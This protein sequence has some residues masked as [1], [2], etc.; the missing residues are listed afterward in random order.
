[1][2]GA[3]PLDRG[4]WTVLGFTLAYLAGFTL[5]FLAAG[6]H[7]FLWYIV[8]MAALIALVA[9]LSRVVSLPL[10]L[11]WALTG[12]GLLHMAGGGVP[13]GDTVLYGAVLLPLVTDGEMTILRYDQAVHAYGF[14]V[15]AW[16]VWRLATGAVP[17]LRGTRTALTLAVL[18][19]MGLGAVNEMVEFAAVVALSETGVG[20]YVNTAL[21]LVFNGLGAVAA[22][23]VIAAVERRRIRAAPG[24]LP[25][26]PC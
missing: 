16:L 12:W 25:R 17:A 21:D 11:L 1:M 22:V 7:E 19:S 15:A 23:L 26:S 4:E 20:G 13:W 18:A 24:R 6:N 8:T 9:W 5:H 14:G 10:A 2:S 3:G